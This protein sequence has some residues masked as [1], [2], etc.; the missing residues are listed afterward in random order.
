MGFFEKLKKGAGEAYDYVAPKAKAAGHYLQERGQALNHEMSET[1]AQERY[2]HR[3]GRNEK[4]E[5]HLKTKG[6]V[7]INGTPYEEVKPRKKVSGRVP[8]KSQPPGYDGN[9]DMFGVGGFGG[10]FQPEER[11]EAP[12]RRKSRRRPARGESAGGFDMNH[13]PDSLRDMF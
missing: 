6:T 3:G 13:V 4:H 9:Y 5:R 11:E 8:R 10:G 12:R 2:E 1:P 7:F